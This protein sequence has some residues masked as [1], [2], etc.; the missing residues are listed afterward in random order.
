MTTA[1]TDTSTLDEFVE[2]LSQGYVGGEW[3]DTLG[4]ESATLVDPGDETPS[5]TVRLGD[6]RDADRAVEAAAAAF[7]DWSGTPLERR[8]ELLERMLDETQARR[9]VLGL[10]CTLTVGTPISISPGR[11]VDIPVGFGRALVEIFRTFEFAKSRGT[12]VIAREPIGVCSLITPWNWPF[13]QSIQKIVAAVGAGNTCIVKPSEF[14]PL[15]A[16]IFAD[17]VDTVGFPAG[18]IN[19]VQGR[20]PVVGERLASHP[21]VALTSITGSTAA[22]AHVARAGAATIKRVLQELGGKSPNV[23]LDDA[24]FSRAVPAG[25]RGAFGNS[26]Q[27]CSALTRMLVPED[28]WDEACAYAAEAAES[29]RIGMPLDPEAELGPLV[30]RAQFD[31]VQGLVAA[32]LDDGAELVTGGLGRP[33]GFDRGFFCRPTVLGVRDPDAMIAQTEIFGPVLVVQPYTDDDDAVRIA[34]NSVYGLAGAV[35]SANLERARAIAVR[36]RVGTVSINSPAFDNQAPSGGYKRSGNGRERGEAG[37][38]D[39]LETKSI[40]GWSAPTP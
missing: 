17:I 39:F 27:S 8:L 2:R 38:S 40:V 29:I 1:V 5:F 9:D 16:A 23:L 26:G 24:D 37:I 18:V 15:D 20:G 21:D 32:A 19:V 33:E 34:N 7:H 14:T 12:T 4:A 6:D 11:H 31:R 30:N 3:V 22:G 10:A 13:G 28:R 25:V 36:L 35:Q